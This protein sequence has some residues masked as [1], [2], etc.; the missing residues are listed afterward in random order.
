MIQQ[1]SQ[2]IAGRLEGVGVPEL[3]WDVCCRNKSGVLHLGQGPIRRTLSIQ[4]G[5][6]TFAT[7]SNPNDRL[8]ES[9]L[10]QAKITLAQLEQA[11]SIQLTGKRLGTLMVESGVLGAE[12]LIAAVSGQI[13]AIVLDLLTWT[14]GEYRFEEGEVPDEDITLGISTGELLLEGLRGIRSCAMVESGAG[15]SHVLHGLSEDWAGRVED[16]RLTEGAQLVIERLVRGP[17]TLRELCRDVCLSSF[18]TCQTLWALKLL[19]IVEP[20]APTHEAD[21]VSDEGEL[22]DTNLASLMVRLERE[23]ETGVLYLTRGASERSL[24]FAAG[25]CVFA[26]SND[27]DD[28][29]VSYLFQRGIISLGDKEEMSRRMLTNRRVGTILRELGAIDDVDLQNMVRLQV[30]EV[31][32]NTFLWE[33]GSFRFEQGSLPVAENITLTSSVGTIVAE[34]IRRITSWTRLVYGCGGIDHV[35]CLTPNY[36]EVLDAMEASVAEWEI[37]S[38]MTTPQTPRRICRLSELADFRVCQIL[39]TLKLLGAVE[40]SPVDVEESTAPEPHVEEPAREPVEQVQAEAPTE[41]AGREEPAAS[42]ELDREFE[43][44][45]NR[46]SDEPPAVRSIN[47]DIDAGEVEDRPAW[48]LPDDVDE[49]IERFNAMHRI[50]FRAI[51]AEIGAGAV[52][53]VRSCCGDMTGKAVDPV[54][55]VD[56]YV[57]G[58]WDADG[59]K[60]VVVEN[61]IEEPWPVYQAVLDRE[62]VTLL[63]ILGESQAAQ[64]KQRIWEVQQSQS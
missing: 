56:L 51:R 40:D 8:G 13:R 63:P 17:E 31:I 59:L 55:G 30:S 20:R 49:I 1:E 50:V 43:S 57:D 39:W 60:L 14:T 35:L 44:P 64:L 36:L 3:I 34:G 58:S 37:V 28:G 27:P 2:P 16:M 6:I 7:S 21:R 12:D 48:E 11:L 38:M 47:L 23:Q 33:Q 54:A 62:F 18:E 45:G 46:D 9:L 5:R 24:F 61:R 32:H 19:G 52:N 41:E 53:F 10:R 22:Q 25:H 15:P 26:T 4:A 29:L 42:M